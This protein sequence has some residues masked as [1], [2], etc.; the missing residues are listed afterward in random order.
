MFTLSVERKFSA[1]HYLI[2]GDWGAENLP[3]AHEYRLELHL[4]GEQLNEHGYLVDI[5]EIE[6][7]LDRELGNYQGVMLNELPEFIGLNPSLENFSQI[8]CLLLAKPMDNDRLTSV[9]VRLW[10]DETAW[11]SYRLEL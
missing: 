6:N 9:E 3:H 8:L 11:A 10:E 4:Q 2:G 7:Q 5:E 1:Q